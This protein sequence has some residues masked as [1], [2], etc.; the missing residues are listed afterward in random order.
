MATTFPFGNELNLIHDG[1]NTLT[2]DTSILNLVFDNQ[3]TNGVLVMQLGTNTVDTAFQIKN[4][5]GNNLFEV[6]GDGTITPAYPTIGSWVF[7][8][9]NAGLTSNPDIIQLAAGS[10]TFTENTLY[11]DDVASVWG[12]G[13]DLT[14]NHSTDNIIASNAGDLIIENNNATGQT[15]IK[16]GTADANTQFVVTDSTT[17]DKLTVDGSGR[18]SIGT[19]PL[20]LPDNV[21]L[22]IGDLPDLT[23]AHNGINSVITSTTGN[24]LVD[25][26][27]AI[28]ATIVQLGTDDSFTA[29]QIKNTSATLFEVKGDGTI[30]P[31]SGASTGNW[32]FDANDAGLVGNPDIIQLTANSV[33]I[34]KDLDLP[35]DKWANFG[36]NFELSICHDNIN[37]TNRIESS[38]VATLSIE[39]TH[40]AGQTQMKLGN[41]DASTSFSV[42]DSG[43]NTLFKVD[44]TGA[45]T[46]NAGVTHTAGEVL[47]T[48]GNLQLNDSITLSLGTGDELSIVHNG[49]NS[50]ITS[51]T[52]NLL[53]D[54]TSATGAT[55]VQLGTNTSATSLQ[56]LNSSS[57]TL[58]QVSG[59]GQSLFNGPVFGETT[60]PTINTD[61]NVTYTATQMINNLIVRSNLT[62]HRTDTFPTAANLVAAINDCAVNTSFMIRVANI[63][64]KSIKFVDNTGVTIV[65]TG[66]TIIGTNVALT[67]HVR[68]TNVT[69]SSEAYQIMFLGRAGM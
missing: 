35:D 27:N 54:N 34:T 48:N 22:Q 4:N 57:T 62:D 58:A 69:S 39:N 40:I 8:G 37:S 45:V 5:T 3:N 12:N 59:A 2:F 36:N 38:Q 24:L 13:N 60:D 17:T 41:T 46:F 33:T 21:E 66:G 52:G 51:T 7:T 67:A 26:T 44:G 20:T 64:T 47:L 43:S 25:N 15:L 50:V 49:P 63:S 18:V 29:F 23:I 11:G 61:S 28:G 30:T 9:N 65:A 31:S 56:V 42:V 10:I 55:I 1:S 14:I 68:V 32:V 19:G 16:L 53:V 6:K